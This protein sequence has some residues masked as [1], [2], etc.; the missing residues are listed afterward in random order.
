MD[1][2]ILG[3][4]SN[5]TSLAVLLRVTINFITLYNLIPTFDSLGKIHSATFHEKPFL[6]YFHAV[7]SLCKQVLTVECL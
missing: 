4:H 5:E 6:L 3:D 7:I 1:K 2:I